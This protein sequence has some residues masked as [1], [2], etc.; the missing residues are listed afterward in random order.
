MSMQLTNGRFQAFDANGDPLVGGQ[1]FTYD[2]GTTTPK[3]TWTDA[4]LATPNANPVLLNA[5]GE[6]LVF[7]GS[8]AYTFVLKDGAGA[9][10]WSVD[11]I[12][13]TGGSLTINLAASSGSNLVGFLQVGAGAVP[14]TVQS[15]LQEVPS[16]K[17][18]GAVADGVTIN[19]FAF[20][21][22]Q[23]SSLTGRIYV[24]AASSPYKIT[25]GTGY[26]LSNLVGDGKILWQGL[27]IDLAKA[28]VPVEKS[29]IE[30][31]IA[32]YAAGETSIGIVCYGDSITAGVNSTNYVDN[33]GNP[34]YNA[35]VDHSWPVM[36]SR[37]VRQLCKRDTADGGF[38][39]Y[40]AGKAGQRMDDGWAFTN[41]Q[42][43]VLTP[44][45]GA[46]SQAIIIGF[47][48]NDA[49]FSGGTSALAFIR[50]LRNLVMLS[51]SYGLEPV[52]F[53]PL[54]I[55]RIR[56]D[57]IYREVGSMIQALVG[58]FRIRTYDP[59]K[60]FRQLIRAYGYS[61]LF[62]AGGDGVHPNDTGYN[63]WATA[64]VRSVAAPWI[65][66]AD[67]EMDFATQSDART[68]GWPLSGNVDAS[69]AVNSTHFDD[70]TL[71]N[72]AV[73][74]NPTLGASALASQSFV[75]NSGRRR[76][77]AVL[78]AQTPPENTGPTDG[79]KVSLFNLSNLGFGQGGSAYL[80]KA[81]VNGWRR[82]TWETPVGVP[83]IVGELTAG[84]TYGQVRTG[85]ANSSVSYVGTLDFVAGAKHNSKR[86]AALFSGTQEIVVNGFG[87]M[88]WN[89]IP[90]GGTD[91]WVHPEEMADLANVITFSGAGSQLN[92]NLSLAEDTAVILMGGSFIDVATNAEGRWAYILR[93]G[94]GANNTKLY[95]Y[96]WDSTNGLTNLTAAPT[97]SAQALGTA[98]DVFLSFDTSGAD[99]RIRLFDGKTSAATLLWTVTS[100]AASSGTTTKVEAPPVAGAAFGAFALGSGSGG[101]IVI[102]S[103]TVRRY[104]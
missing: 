14:R 16:V 51:R 47:G 103:A 8:G 12:E 87:P 31:L 10:I 81:G 32:R 74:Y 40:N 58:E 28:R 52:L 75:W 89:L 68:S 26:D 43:Y 82:L 41:F 22:A 5:R 54:P 73:R 96:R 20:N 67:G 4:A 99:M 97:A 39:F 42:T 94:S 90:G 62:G 29:G 49:F 69:W 44:Y 102:N 37:I 57:I 27:T 23:A 53:T 33:T 88:R 79:I 9:T 77:Y 24:P 13:D 100:G 17:D 36:A 60:Y 63:A 48:V 71:D 21:T 95:L 78:R 15:K 25:F 45:G 101:D 93:R 18:Y 84:L 83:G 38:L 55:P 56:N 19:D 50:E 76:V 86:A 2:S 1:L 104:P 98:A 80:D 66:D 30:A 3:T 92:L 34:L 11:G 59:A 64:I 70:L 85:A 72:L 91:C 46:K 6:A 35:T 7:L 61:A 65:V